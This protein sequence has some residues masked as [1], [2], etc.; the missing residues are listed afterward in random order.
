MDGWLQA[1]FGAFYRIEQLILSTT[2]RAEGHYTSAESGLP[3]IV[4]D[5]NI[6]LLFA[7]QGQV[8]TSACC[9][10]PCWVLCMKSLACRLSCC[11]WVTQKGGLSYRWCMHVGLTE[12]AIPV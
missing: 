10:S 9:L 8:K 4:S 2:P 5:A 6:R 1:S 7:V 12:H 3:S 11:H